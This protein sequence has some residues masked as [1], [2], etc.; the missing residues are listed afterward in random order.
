MKIGIVVAMQK[1]LDPFLQGKE[2]TQEQ[3]KNFPHH[4]DLLTALII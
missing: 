4:R 1:E 2:V 3:I